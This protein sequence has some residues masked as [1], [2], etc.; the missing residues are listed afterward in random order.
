MF[1]LKLINKPKMMK[2]KCN[3]TFPNI[4]L[5][6]LQE[7]EA[8]PT[9]EMQQIIADQQYDGLSKVV[10]NA[11]PD[12]YIIPS[13]ELEIIQNGIYDVSS[14]A[15]AKVNV[16][17]PTG[18]IDITENGLHNVKDKE[19]AN[20]NVPEKQLG[21][22]T[23]TKNGTYKASD[24]NLDGYS[25]VEVATSGVD[26]NDYIGD[27]V[28][29]SSYSIP[30]WI[31]LIK[32][33]PSPLIL[34]TTAPEYMFKGIKITELPQ[35]DISEATSI[36]GMFYGCDEL[37]EIPNLNIQNIPRF[38]S[39]FYACNKLITI[40]KLN[41]TNVIDIENCFRSCYA[42]TNLG[43]LENLGQAYLT[44]QSAN[45]GKYKL[46]LSSSSKLTET[47]LINVLNNLYDIKSKGCNPQS[48]VLGSTNISKLSAEEIQIA[49]DKGFSVS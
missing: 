13:G 2:L 4:V 20:V 3:F 7:K 5:A 6:N 35:I 42:L 46:D 12:E 30:G 22:K 23:I 48:L 47:S 45:N 17:M 41:A 29:T 26:I 27:T 16:P 24:D 28:S 11:I 10:V 36:V 18:T 19:F 43:G 21:T 40:P 49:T 38:Y 15:S 39:L 8:T 25:Q 31:T 37:L 14:K 32:K 34:E 33:L 1:K 9:K 44:T